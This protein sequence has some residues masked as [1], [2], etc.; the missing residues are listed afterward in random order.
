MPLIPSTRKCDTFHNDHKVFQCFQW[1]VSC[2]VS[3]SLNDPDHDYDYIFEDE[4]DYYFAVDYD[5]HQT[6]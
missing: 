6:I 1:G 3:F 2:I 5:N 4:V